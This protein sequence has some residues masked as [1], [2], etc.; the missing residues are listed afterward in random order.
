MKTLLNTAAVL[1][2][3]F[4]LA[5]AQSGLKVVNVSAV[6]VQMV[7]T[8]EPLYGSTVP[9]ISPGDVGVQGPNQSARD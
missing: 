2:M 8:A 9:L 5:S 4:T 3:S 6:P 1:F 7:V